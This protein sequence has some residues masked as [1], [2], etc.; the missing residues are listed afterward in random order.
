VALALGV[1][2]FGPPAAADIDLIWSPAEQTV[3]LDDTVE[4]D[5]I[6]VSDDASTQYFAALD[7]IIL[8]DPAHLDLIGVDDAHAGYPFVS[9]HFLPDPDGLNTNLHDGDALFTALAPGGQEAPVP[10]EGLVITRFE[11]TA[12]GHTPGTEVRFAETM[13]SYA[14]T[15]LRQLDLSDVTG[16]I[17]AT[18]WVKIVT[19]RTGDSD[20]DDDVDLEDF[21]NFQKCFTGD[22]I[23]A[24]PECQCYFDFDQDLD[25]DLG[26]YWEF[27]QR[28]MG[29]GS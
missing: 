28:L 7:A 22:G 19:C 21:G 18:G 4:L 25:V 2:T 5:L 11:F 27:E 8:W 3:G 13:S 23:E 29:P 15:R 17:S 12:V 24:T 1:G 20:Q 26:D 9:S 14:R 10:P 6:A 16:D